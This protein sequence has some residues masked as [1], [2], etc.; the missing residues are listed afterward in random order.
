[1]PNPLVAIP[2]V[3][4]LVGS[5]GSAAIQAGAAGAAADAQV[6]ASERGIEEQRRQFEVVRE[7]LDPFVQGG[8][9]AF[10]EQL[11]LLGLG[12]EGAEQAAIDRI[13]SG[14]QFTELVSQSEEA[15][16]GRGS[17]TGQLRGGNTQR[18]LA[19]LR[20]N[21]LNQLIAS[22]QNALGGIAVSGQNAAGAV[23][24]AAQRTGDQVTNLLTQQGSARSGQALAG[25][26][27][28]AD[29]LANLSQVAGQIVPQIPN[30]GNPF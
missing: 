14:G 21:I 3:I 5:V 24:G 22:R 29:L 17:A 13:T 15:I 1:M 18:A 2:A 6:E 4:G 9:G 12:E 28:G 7:L 30:I 20:P 27:I 10:A 16:L 11:D 25:G 19:E 8:Q 23:G 26:Q